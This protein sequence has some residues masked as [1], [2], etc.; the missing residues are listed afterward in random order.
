M[1]RACDCPVVF[2]AAWQHHDQRR[3]GRRRES[4][5]LAALI[6]PTGLTQVCVGLPGSD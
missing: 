2:G 5:R 3:S 6:P 1:E 4:A